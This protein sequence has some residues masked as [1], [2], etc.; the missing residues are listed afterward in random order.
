MR[1]LIKRTLASFLALTMLLTCLPLPSLAEQMEAEETR[2][3][4]LET[5][6]EPSS[7]TETSETAET[8]A[9]TTAA[10]IPEETETASVPETTEE[11][12]V[13]EEAQE[14]ITAQEPA[15]AEEAKAA[16]FE[17]S[18]GVLK[19]YNGTAVDVVIPEGVT[20]I[21]KNSFTGNKTIQSVVIPQGVMTI[22]GGA[23]YYTEGAFQ[24]C[25]ELR[26]VEIRS[27][28]L[29][30][31]G[32][33]AFH[34]CVK[35]E[36]LTLNQGLTDINL[37]A[38]KDCDRLEAVTIPDGV[39]YL[40][41]EAFANCNAL[42]MVTLP[43]TLAKTG[44]GIFMNTPLEEITIPGKLKIIENQSFQ[45][46]TSLKKVI[47]EDGVGS[48]ASGAEYYTEGAFRNCTSLQ[49]LE[50]R[51]NDLT[52]IGR[53]AF[54]G[55]TRLEN[56]SLCEG[57]MNIGMRA[58]SS[59]TYLESIQIPEGVE[60]LGN[61][62]F[63]GCTSLETVTLPS[64]LREAG[65]AVFMNTALKE[66]TIPG[67]LKI[68]ENQ[69]FQN[70]TSLKKVIIEDG[71]ESIASGA[72]YYTEGAFRN[73]TSLETLEIR[74]D[75]LKTIGTDAFN[76]C[77]RLENVTLC[78]GLMNIGMRAFSNCTYLESIQIPE[79]VETLGNSAFAGCTS[80]ETV[81]LPSS[82][83][84]AGEA[85]F[86]N[87]A[88]KEVTIPGKLKTIK[89]Q[90]FQNC[91]SLK[92]VVIEDGVESIAS[93]AEYYTEGAFRNCTSLETLEIRSDDLKTIG[94]D[95]FNGCKS[96]EN[97]TLCEG[98][99]N[100]GMRAFSNCT[101]LES[102]QIPEGVETLGNSA[103]AGCTG[104]KTVTLPSTLRETGEA[105]FMNSGLEEVTIPGKLK[106]I[107]NQSF[108]NCTSLKKVIIEDGVESIAS[109]A[110]YYTEGAFRNC[111]SLETLEIRSDDLLFIGTDAFN[112]CTRLKNVILCEGLETIGLRAF[113]NCT[114]LE[115]LTIPASVREINK[116]AFS[117]SKNLTL[118]VY[119]GSYGETFCIDNNLNYKIV[120]S[121]PTLSW[122]TVP[123]PLALTA[124]DA[125]TYTLEILSDQAWTV[126]VP[127]WLTAE[128]ASGEGN[129]SITIH[130][131]ANTGDAREGQIVIS[132]EGC[133]DL[134]LAVTQEAKANQS[135]TLEDTSD[136]ALGTSRTLKAYDPEGDAISA[137]KLK[138][139]TSDKTV[140]TVST[141]GKI[142][143][144]KLGT[145]TITAT[146]EDG[147]YACADITVRPK[148]KSVAIQYRG[149]DAGKT[150]NVDFSQDNEITLSAVVTPD[151][152]SDGVT[153]KSS[154]T[155]IAEV[156]KE[157]GLVR[158]HKT[159]K[160]TIT[161]ATADGSG[162]KD[163]VSLNV[164]LGVEEIKIT[165]P[166]Q[167]AAGKSVTLKA[168][169]SPED[170]T[171]KSVTWTTSDAKVATVSSSGKVTAKKVSGFHYVT[172]TAAAKDGTGAYAE[173]EILV[174]P[175]TS[176]VQIQRYGK[177]VSSVTYDIDS[178]DILQFGAKTTPQDASDAV[179][180]TSSSTKVAQIDEE[181]GIVTVHKTG[182][183]TITATALDGSGK[184]DTVKLEVVR[185]VKSLEIKGPTEVTSGKSV[186][187]KA[188]VGPSDASS[189]S[190]TWTSSNE[191]VAKVSSSG[192]VT[193]KK[194]K[195]RESVIITAWAKDESGVSSSV[196]LAVCPAADEVQI[197]RNGLEV[198][199]VELNR[200]VSPILELDAQVLPKNAAQTVTW[201]SSN[202]KVAK[203]DAQ[204][205]TVTGL[206]AG[207][208]TI[209]ATT[210]NG[211]KATCKVKVVA[212]ASDA[213]ISGSYVYRVIQDTCMISVY[214]GSG[215][216]LVVPGEI[217]GYPVTAIGAW[218]FEGHALTECVIPEGVVSI[219]EGAFYACGILKKVTLPASVDTIADDAFAGCAEDLVI[220][221]ESGSYAQRYALEQ[222]LGFV[223]QSAPVVK[224]GI[225]VVTDQN[226]AGYPEAS[227]VLWDLAQGPYILNWKA[228]NASRYDVKILVLDEAPDFSPS[229]SN[230]ST[231]ANTLYS[232]SG[233]KLTSLKL[234]KELPRG[235][236]LKVAVGAYGFGSAPDS[237]LVFGLKL[238][239]RSHISPKREAAVARAEQ[240]YQ[241]IWTTTKTMTLWNTSNKVP[242]GVK[243]RGLPY[244]MH[245]CLYSIDG[246]LPRSGNYVAL[247]EAQKYEVASG[248]VA[249]YGYRV[250]P[251]FGAECV[252]LVYDAW[253]HGDSAIGCRDVD[254]SKIISKNIERG[255]VEQI[256][257]TE[258]R[259]ADAFGKS[260]HIMLCIAVD[261]KGTPADASDDVFTVIEQTAGGLGNAAEGV[262]MIGTAKN[263]YTYKKLVDDGYVPYCYNVLDK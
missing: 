188:I 75:D 165:G 42:K 71:V 119:A 235:K 212:T 240:W 229:G 96:L 18:N 137:K 11:L 27:T 67:K 184:K 39:E 258:A 132:A 180:W 237:W 24:N 104:L 109:G 117:G 123:A 84:E 116:N 78:E 218:V 43:S 169:V 138:W 211:K 10:S 111:T 159:G 93:G 134:T 250:G 80:L 26:T 239:D 37:R 259:P 101:Y 36:N 69:S 175:A 228:E 210:A 82:L 157:T 118:W 50:I 160:A 74:S 89:N 30:T 25:T 203:V 16:E 177:D 262:Y 256:S 20:S 255:I 204:T 243:V 46:C 199:T 61:S 167:V 195:T 248:D 76:G 41:A 172:I 225:P 125:G 149:D 53:D 209:T 220:Y 187:L 231:A 190:V 152:A 121:E 241:Y 29:T 3:Q 90:S 70:C 88:L 86:M 1:N 182:K 21:A 17:I 207:T 55:C 224:A 156:D 226:N 161:A 31:I 151:G 14:P 173:H 85:V 233:T 213:Q 208:A 64:S 72:E 163:T 232:L 51:S 205:G 214:R 91:T 13:P 113:A 263:T 83:R 179:K 221:G 120:G 12:T 236:Y 77:K 68:I 57:L 59:C 92:K 2:E 150:I 112:G 45:N 139:S 110:E 79:G 194:V 106:T 230:Q 60:T 154:S 54:N 242:S 253:Y 181:T 56:V 168:K 105:V 222:G 135:I 99:M 189:K 8:E 216:N 217:A 103:F 65:E 166:S 202:K 140:L 127:A 261:Q 66:V 245:N 136:I 73:C 128:P 183:T 130:A 28:S 114:A 6:T 238:V 131:Q 49:T 44:T 108:Q 215:G 97:V 81:T 146:A 176:K 52:V 15:A 257:W 162:K 19:K 34:G 122:K 87:T 33:D 5:E 124:G 252:Q 201:K 32:T 142:T 234:D 171:T 192:K 164:V 191:D 47:I 102:I 35:L 244:T 38:F 223:S 7:V 100:I 115:N 260:S 148:V 62:A 246:T 178:D 219:G 95:A 197:L 155:K 4:I 40:G 186:T 129:G 170:A 249:G 98:L 126:T 147:S 58:F 196:E 254:W 251:K 48:I 94:T 143:A 63:A 144:K 227:L 23:Q 22:Q 133:S 193:A 141:S 206:K 200:E 145:A 198:K 158:I 9:E 153:W 185:N 247:K 107:K 174:S